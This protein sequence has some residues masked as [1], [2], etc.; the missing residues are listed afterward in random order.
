MIIEI[1][2]SK[3]INILLL[4]TI[5]HHYQTTLIIIYIYIYNATCMFL[6]S[7]FNCL[8]Y[9]STMYCLLLHMSSCQSLNMRR[10]IVSLEF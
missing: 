6:F 7:Y 2:L 9:L 5:Y 4:L 10:W 1:F 8:S 3:T